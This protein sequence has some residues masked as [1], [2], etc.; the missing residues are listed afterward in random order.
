[1]HFVILSV[2]FSLEVYWRLKG[3]FV[4]NVID[5]ERSDLSSF[6]VTVLGS[7]TLII[8]L[9]CLETFLIKL[10]V[11]AFLWRKKI[12]RELLVGCVSCS[13]SFNNRFLN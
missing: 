9:D 6:S 7:H 3:L 5:Q 11:T 13:L 4:L 12:Q 1:M 8:K 2:T 10:N